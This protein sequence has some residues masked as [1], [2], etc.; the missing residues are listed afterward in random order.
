MGKYLIPNYLGK[1]KCKCGECRNSCCEGWTVTM[2]L[3]EYFKI[4]NL[5]C[6]VEFRDKLD[7]G[8][9]KCI[10]STSDRYAYIK[11]N[12]FGDCVFHGS[13]GLC[14]LHKT[15]GSDNIPRV[16]D[17]YPRSYKEEPYFK[18]SCSNSCEGVL[19]LLINDIEKLEFVEYTD[20]NELEM[21]CISL[22][23]E[24]KP[25]AEK[26][27]EIGKL[28]GA[29]NSSVYE[30]Q[31]LLVLINDYMLL[32]KDHHTVEEFIDNII[33]INNDTS[34]EENFNNFKKHLY[35]VIPDYDKYISKIMANH[36]LFTDFPY[37]RQ[38]YN[39]SFYSLCGVYAF[40]NYM[41]I[42]IMRDKNTLT[43]LV[44]ALSKIFRLIEHSKFPLMIGNYIKSKLPLNKVHNLAKF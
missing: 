15:F 44:D 39:V 36:I 40:V 29:N 8:I 9:Y 19:E 31:K 32:Y 21:R 34:I 26:F 14:E 22:I 42:F 13:D 43:D 37:E 10:D 28:F 12:Y 17:M 27:I 1:F 11:K 20:N 30:F 3:N 4:N 38:G 25:V 35:E 18:K 5:D 24:D 7:R 33:K 23:Q 16:C 2:S 41:V 6:G